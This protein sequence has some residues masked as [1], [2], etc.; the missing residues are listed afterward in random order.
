MKYNA[1][2]PRAYH[3]RYL[4]WSIVPPFHNMAPIYC[5]VSWSMADYRCWSY[6]RLSLSFT[7]DISLHTTVINGLKHQIKTHRKVDRSSHLEQARWNVATRLIVGCPRR[8]QLLFLLCPLKGVIY[9]CGLS[10]HCSLHMFLLWKPR[11][12]HQ[13]QLS[14]FDVYRGRRVRPL[15]PVCVLLNTTNDLGEVCRFIM[16]I[17]HNPCRLHKLECWRKDSQAWPTATTTVW[18]YPKYVEKKSAM[19]TTNRN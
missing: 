10:K 7:L 14:Q 18:L 2:T 17:H 11:S 5:H 19:R 15:P 9:T 8:K 3:G 12:P 13:R 1:T 6:V 16:T 4:V